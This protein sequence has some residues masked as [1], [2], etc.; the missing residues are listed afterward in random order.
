MN[1]LVLENQDLVLVLDALLQALDLTF[2]LNDGRGLL[3]DFQGRLLLR[4]E[5]LFI[6]ELNLLDSGIKFGFLLSMSMHR[7]RVKVLQIKQ[8]LG[9]RLDSLAVV[10]IRDRQE[11]VVDD[12]HVFML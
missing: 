11:R 12:V 2:E 3:S 7:I 8:L 9:Q 6:L 4:F 1:P 10:L 5:G